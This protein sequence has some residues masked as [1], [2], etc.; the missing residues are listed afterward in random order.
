MLVVAGETIVDM[1]A[2]KDAPMT[3]D[4]FLGGGPYNVAK[5]AVKM[6]QAT[7]YLSPLSE[8]KFGDAFI[9]EM[10][11]LGLDALAPRSSKASGLAIVQTDETGHP[12]YTFHRENAADRDITEAAIKANFPQDASTFYVGGLALADG[13][14]ADTWA[15]FCAVPNCPVFVDPNIRPSFITDRARFM[16]RLDQVYDASDIIKL[17]DE[18]IDW[19]APSR[20]PRNYMREVMSMH[21][22]RIGFLTHGA[23]GAE[24]YFDGEVAMVAAPSIKVQD[25]VGAGDCFSAASIACINRTGGLDAQSLDAL[26]STLQYSVAAAAINCTRAGANAPTD[27]EVRA[28]LDTI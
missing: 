28:F 9:S 13:E 11:S 15:K 20:D 17:S 23:K 14:D 24:V 5:A 8:D 19:L 27:A 25:T 16:T 1:I 12:S 22:I 2:R 3:L 21:N 10:Q 26:K 7:G 6:G 18:D 4:A